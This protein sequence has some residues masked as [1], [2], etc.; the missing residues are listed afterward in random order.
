MT[1]LYILIS[2]LAFSSFILMHELGHYLA[3]RRFGV[4][5]KEFSIGMGPRLFSRTSKKTGIEYKLCLFPFGGYVSMV[6][7]DEESDDPNSLDKKP[8]WQ[9]FII[10]AAGGVTNLAVGFL[11]VLL[12]VSLISGQLATTTIDS[13]PRMKDGSDVPGY[14][15][16]LREGDTILSVDGRRVYTGAELDYEIMRRGINPVTLEIERDGAVMTLTNC[17]LYS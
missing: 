1:V 12:T 17:K 3:A 7:E 9:R 10:M 15:A 4:T 16:G 8:I 5:V 6:G 11:L 13:F 2:I 14:V